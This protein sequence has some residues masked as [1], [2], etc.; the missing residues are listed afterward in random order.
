KR[1]TISANARAWQ[2]QLVLARP[3]AYHQVIQADDLVEKHLLVDRR[4][5]DVLLTLSQAVGQQAAREVKPGTVLTA[6]LVEPLP[7]A[8]VGQFVTVTLVQ[9]TVRVKTV[10]RAMEGGTFGQTIKAK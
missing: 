5:D 9:G 6:R 8:R 4:N 7:L 2:T 1:V 10:A 3:L